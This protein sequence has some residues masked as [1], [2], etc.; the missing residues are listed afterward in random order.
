MVRFS[1]YSYIDNIS[2]IYS[3]HFHF[4]YIFFFFNFITL[5]FFYGFKTRI[6]LY[7]YYIRVSNRTTPV[8]M[9]CSKWRIYMF[10]TAEIERA[11]VIMS[12]AYYYYYYYQALGCILYVQQ[13]SC[14]LKQTNKRPV[15]TRR[16]FTMTL[17]VRVQFGVFNIFTYLY[18]LRTYKYILQLVRQLTTF[19]FFTSRILYNIIY[20]APTEQHEQPKMQ[21]TT[22]R[23]CRYY[24]LFYT[25]IYNNIVFI[26][27]SFSCHLVRSKRH[28]AAYTIVHIKIMYIKNNNNNKKYTLYARFGKLITRN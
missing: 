13:S 14:I 11:S 7:M 26:N 27:F 22:R 9:F 12:T 21:K 4:Y 18:L 8:R 23:R 3:S 15:E 25:C 16:L 1:I 17:Y 5:S 24:Q 10:C 6:N 19:N 20:L 28:A 2:A